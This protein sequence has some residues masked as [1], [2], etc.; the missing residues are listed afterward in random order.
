MHTLLSS[1]S[2]VVSGAE[3][4]EKKSIMANT[5]TTQVNFIRMIASLLMIIPIFGEIISHS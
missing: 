3:D 1:E 2:T 5:R 4:E